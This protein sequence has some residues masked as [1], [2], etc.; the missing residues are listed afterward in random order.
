LKIIFSYLTLLF[1]TCIPIVC[2]AQKHDTL[3]SVK[4]IS[5]K[6][7]DI[8]ATTTP[9]QQL[10][11]EQLQKINS[12]TVADAVKQF[13]G[14]QVKD[15]GGIGGLKTV[16]VRSLGAN[17]TGVL[18]DGIAIADAQGGQIDL[19]KFSL[20]NIDNIQLYN[21]NS[22]DILLPARAFA[23]ASLLSIKSSSSIINR[24]EKQILKIKVQQGSFGY[25]SPSLLYKIRI[26][27]KFQTS[28]SGSYQTAKSEYPFVSYENNALTETRKNSDINA[29]RVEYD[30]VYFKNDSNKI[31]FKTYYYNSKRGLPGS[32]ILYNNTSN[33]RLNDENF[34]TQATWQ[35]KLNDKNEFLISTKLSLDKN[36]YLDPSYPNN[37][38]KLENDFHQK[39]IYVSAAYKYAIAKFVEL[40]YASDYFNSTLNRTDIFADSFANP[41]RNTFLN[42]IAFQ[43]KKN[44]FEING[45]LLHTNITE[46]VTNGKAG[47]NLNALTPAL[48]TVFQ[49]FYNH[50]FRQAGIQLLFRAFYK[51]IFRAPTFNDLY[52]TN[53]GNVNLKPEVADQFNVGIT[54]STNNISFLDKIIV[55]T[56]AY[57]NN[58][59]DKILAVPRQNLFQWSMQNIGRVKIKGLDA[60]LHLLFKEISG[61]QLSS[62]ISYT[63]QQALDI[64]DATLTSFKTQLPYTPMHTGSVNVNAQYKKATLSYNVLASSYGYRQ[65]DAIAENLLQGWSSHDVSFAYTL[66]ENYKIVAEANN[67]LNNQ[68]EIIRYYPMPR[69]NYR[70]SFIV[71]FKK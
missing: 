57:I 66:K 35:N 17:H 7:K 10:N 43:I 1:F 31:K 8:A 24:A 41:T 28:I 54:F 40:S 4:V 55:T 39:E 38:G 47:R 20:D 62:N 11:N 49:P 53:I 30:A 65:G 63:F 44:A 5:K 37:F 56:D 60:T 25:F 58:V 12:I 22:T 51:H 52:F 19:G 18:Y 61:V 6:E 67:F 33:Q 71:N 32:I 3:A 42:N 14:V 64:S 46:K 15:Y 26:G 21:S 34:F 23:S 45:N 27:E 70:I 2:V 59:S 69:F 50:A 68:Y 36:Y 16:S 48:S 9:L 29:Y 13:A